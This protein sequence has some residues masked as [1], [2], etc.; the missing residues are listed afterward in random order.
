MQKIIIITGTSG[1][2]KTTLANYLLTSFSI[3]KKVI[4]CT[5]RKK[6]PLE[7]AGVDYKFFSRKKFTDYIKENKFAEFE[8]YSGNYYGSLKKDVE[9]I[10]KNKN[11]V[12][13]VV[14]PKGAL[15]LS[16]FF[17]DS[18]SIF[19][20]APSIKELEKRLKNRGDSSDKIKE[21]INLV[22]R[23]LTF[24]KKFDFVLINDDLIKS[25]NKLKKLL[26][27]IV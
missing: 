6:R 25:K 19:I 17:T 13:F 12:L 11:N 21:R 2:G 5:T 10:I 22:K 23:D 16:K 24:E 26:G 20:K 9:K 4:T 7:K 3:I 27:K 8:K 18:I 15:T 1:S 14:D